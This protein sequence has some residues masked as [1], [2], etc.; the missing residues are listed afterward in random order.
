MPV[1]D[2]KHDLD[3]LSLTITAEFAAPVTR[4]WQIY[5]DP[6]QLEKVWG[7]PSHPA[8][9]VDHD[10]RPGGRV[11]YFMTGPDGE[12][13]AGYWEITAVDEPHSF[14]FLDGFA[15]EDFNPNTDLPVSTNV[16]TFTEHDGGTRA[17]YVGT[18]ASAEALQQVLD[19]GVIE[20]ASSAINQ[21]DA[22][23]TA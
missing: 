2:V 17:T 14:S 15:D 6:R 9:V 12:K 5:A 10:L 20:G 19:M 7:P 21:I 1:T 18:Y 22:L 23:L 3:T 11:T 8:T 13:Y 4:I 16:Y